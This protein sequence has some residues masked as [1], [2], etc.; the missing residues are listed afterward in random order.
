M[1]DRFRERI[2]E[3]DIRGGEVPSCIAVVISAEAV[4]ARW[5]RRVGEVAGWCTSLGVCEVA[6][7]SEV[8]GPG[9]IEDLERELADL[10]TKGRLIIGVEETSF[11][12]GGP[13]DLVISAGS[14]GREEVTS[15]I[16][17]LLEDVKAGLIG[18]EAI[19]EEAIEG[20]LRLKL[21][22]DLLIRLGHRELSDFMI[23]QS[24][25]SELYFIDRSW[26]GLKKVDFL[27]AVRDYQS[28][29]RRFGR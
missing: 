15:A 4:G 20:R 1:L 10:P 26:E 25:Y 19:D 24:A 9:G 28:R 2:I 18:P 14:G 3:R 23:W 6:L 22:P 29:E 7:F 12:K 27:L 21:R 16:R 13:L 8:L 5:W 17:S 11:G